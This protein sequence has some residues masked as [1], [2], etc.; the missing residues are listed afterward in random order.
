MRIPPLAKTISK[1]SALVALAAAAILTAESFDQE[2]SFKPTDKAYYADA[3]TVAFVRPGLSMKITDQKITSDGTMS[4]RLTIADPTGLPLDREGITTPGAVSISCAMAYIP[5]SQSASSNE[6]VA[7]T[8]R[9]QTSTITGKSATQAG[10]DSGGTWTKNADGDYTYNFKTKA[11]ANYDVS[12]THRVGCQ[13]SRNLTEFDLG[14]N[15]ATV[16]KDFVP[17]GGAIKS[18]HDIVRDQGCNNCHGEIAFHGGSRRGTAYCVMCHT[19]QTTDPDT[20]NTVD[21]PV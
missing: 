4:V 5:A 2:F 15:Y 12:A 16:T 21:F 20:G 3:N 1:G 6:F 10:T 8:T 17:N 18:T 9:V 7:Y 13:A 11:P 19:E 14:T